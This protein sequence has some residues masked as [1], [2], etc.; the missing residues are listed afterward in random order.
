M[1]VSVATNYRRGSYRKDI[2]VLT[3]D[4]ANKEITFSIQATILE[5]LSALPAFVDFGRVPV[6]ARKAIDISL[7]NNGAEPIVIRQVRVSPAEHLRI[8]PPQGFSLNPGEKKQLSLTLL[9]TLTP[10]TM[11]G[12]V[13]I[14]TDTA[15]LPEKNISVRAEIITHR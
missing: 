8:S 12:S 4:P 13:L 11:N 15:H 6:G 9:A 5:T 1:S 2:Q 10:G 7:S 3:N 14:M